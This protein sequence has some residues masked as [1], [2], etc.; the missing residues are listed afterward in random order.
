MY[1][2]SLTVTDYCGLYE[3]YVS[4]A[5]DIVPKYSIVILRAFSSAYNLLT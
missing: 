1:V 2:F 4:V 3:T 5:L